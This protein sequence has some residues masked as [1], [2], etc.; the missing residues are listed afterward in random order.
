MNKYDKQHINNIRRYQRKIDK[1]YKTAAE[2]IAQRAAG[3]PAPED[4]IFS[5][6]DHPRTMEAINALMDD[7]RKQITFTVTDGVRAEWDLA[8]AK[9]DDMVDDALAGRAKAAEAVRWYRQNIEA[10]DAFLGRVENGMKLSDRVWNYTNQ[11]KQ[12]IELGLDCGIR[13]GL[14]APA[15]ARQLK[16]YLKYPDKLFR[17]VRDEHGILRL[18]KRAAAFHPGRG[19]YRSSYKN[20]RRLAATETNMAYR[21]ADYDRW[22]QL[23]M[24]VGVEIRLSNNHTCLNN[25]GKAVAFYDI[26]DE[27]KGKYPKD[28]KFV[29]WHPHCRCIMTPIKKSREEIDADID[30]L[31]NGQP[32]LPSESSENYVSE[33]PEGWDKWMENNQDRL[34][35]AK[36][37]PYFIRDNFVDGDPSQGLRW[38]RPV[39]N[40]PKLSPQEIAEQRHANRD[41]DAVIERWQTRQVWNLMDDIKA[42]LLPKEA[43]KGVQEISNSI[44][45]G[46]YEYASRRITTYQTAVQRHAARTQNQAQAIRDAWNA[47]REE[48]RLIELGAKNMLKVAA[49][50]GESDVAALQKAMQLGEMN[51]V[52]KQTKALAQQLLDIRAQEKALAD[53]IPDVHMWH[54]QFTMAELKKAHSAVLDKLT[55]IAPWSLEAQKKA[56]EKEI[57]YVADPTFM[58]PHSLHPT[59]KVA[60]DAYARQLSDV[61]YKIETKKISQE[62]AP[63]EQWLAEHPKA[64]KVASLVQDVK[65]A[66]AAGEDLT[67]IN[68]KMLLAKLDYKKRIAAQAYRDRQKLK[69]AAGSADF[70]ASCFT[71]ERRNNA[72]WNLTAKEADAH[73]HQN[74]V[75]FWK[76]VNDSE[77]EALW[78]YTAGSGYITKPLRAIPGYEYDYLP[79]EAKAERHIRA[80]TT[81]LDKQTLKVDTWLKRDSDP[82]NIDYIFGIDLEKFKGDPSALV[83]KVGLE[84]SFQ[85]CGSCRETRFTCTGPKKVIMNLYC[86][87]GTKAVYA[88]PWSSCGTYGRR[89]DGVSRA[90]PS[91]YSE[92]E[93]I[94]Q[95]GAKM[96]IT[97]A[98]YKNGMWYIDVDVL[99]FDIR[100][101]EMAEN[102]VGFYCKFK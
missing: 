4:D 56:L 21:Q 82:W 93:V 30:R 7:M 62:L 5:L 81:A 42:G 90:N 26:C 19:V 50:Y 31:L 44:A 63:I 36:S 40:T 80:M 92:N 67:S 28:F 24:V 49:D 54:Q 39:T 10:R 17:R 76:V 85:S 43:F 100:E 12:E 27:L 74:A 3:L 34:S 83:G 97:K 91:K 2:E 53:L 11:F 33:M 94:L 71:Q 77:K 73:F 59:W 9:N 57:K 64:S 60:Q 16:Q 41:D 29:G 35:R 52:K 89:W 47:E 66:I 15:M 96:R 68:D 38:M 98:E 48:K 22:Q 69:K 1:I 51:A 95:R 8:N 25:K 6:D 84:D 13:D 72:V 55:D 102:S 88:E 75:E 18:S 37:M 14:D 86:P 46:D 45:L 20:A 78:G 61:I 23:E 58:K 70:D 32:A 101:F 79:Y 87:K 99:G 65:D